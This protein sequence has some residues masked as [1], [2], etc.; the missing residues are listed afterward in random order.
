MITYFMAVYLC[1][2]SKITAFAP[3]IQLTP[4]IVTFDYHSGNYRRE[5]WL[6]AFYCEGKNAST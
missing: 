4:L 2:K 3:K 1:L 5:N 6:L